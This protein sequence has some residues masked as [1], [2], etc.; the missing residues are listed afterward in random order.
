[1]K[2]QAFPLF[3]H[4]MANQG[5]GFLWENAITRDVF[6]LEEALPYTSVFDVDAAHNTLNPEENVS[7]KAAC[8]DKAECGDAFRIFSYG[9]AAVTMIHIQYRQRD[10]QTKELVRLREFRLGGAEAH[11]LLFGTVTQEEINAL[12]QMTR[13]IPAGPIPAATKAAIHAEKKRLNAKSGGIRFNP[14]MDSKNQRRLQCSIP[15]LSAFLT[16]NPSLVVSD[17]TQ[18]LVRGI[19]IPATVP[20]GRRQRNPRV[21]AAQ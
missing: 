5:H 14:K 2:A 9:D 19:P 10:P 16:A 15:K 7:I 11:R 17:T 1:L 20:S 3:L 18:P 6:H 8:G 13:A 4:K 12:I 21:N